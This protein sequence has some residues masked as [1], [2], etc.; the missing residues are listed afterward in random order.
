[1]LLNILNN[2]DGGS[3]MPSKGFMMV[4]I[5]GL[6]TIIIFTIFIFSQKSVSTLPEVEPD[7][8]EINLK[9]I[10]LHSD[11]VVLINNGVN[12]AQLNV[13]G[14][15]ENGIEADITEAKVVFASKNE[16]V[17]TVDNNTGV[18]IPVDLGVVELEA[19]VTLNDKILKSS[20]QLGVSKRELTVEDFEL[21]GQYGSEDSYVERVGANHFKFYR[22]TNRFDSTRK[23]LPQFVIPS[24]FKGNHLIVD[25]QGLAP[26]SGGHNQ[27]MS[28][29]YDNDQWTPVLQEDLSTNGN[30]V[31]RITI[32]PSSNDRLYFGW[33]IPMSY[34][35]G[36]ELIKGWSSHPDTSKY[37][38]LEKLGESYQG[39]EIVKM[40]ITDP[41][42]TVPESERWVHYV[43]H[44]HPHEGKARWR[45]KGLVDWLVSDDPKAKDSRERSIWHVVLNLNPDGANNGFLRH[46][47]GEYPNLMTNDVNRNYQAFQGANEER[48]IKEIYLFQRDMEKLMESNT[49]VHSYWDFHVWGNQVEPILRRG[50]ELIKEFPQYIG[51]Y[52][53]LRDIIMDNDPN[54]L[55][56]PL[57]AQRNGLIGDSTLDGGVNYQFRITSVLVEGGGTLD[58]QEE[59]ESSGEILAKS[60]SQFYRDTP[61]TI[62]AWSQP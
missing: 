22:G 9:S 54:G 8:P 56:K 15:Y 26:P 5:G 40:I 43:S 30:A 61:S 32:A 2:K 46:A 35:R 23:N 31:S 19:T 21:D 33:S 13:T 39:R 6:L 38:K 1:M 52:M 10:K 44:E 24:N 57:K 28:Y 34:E 7:K 29:S 27:H 16:K 3:A 62:E 49:P 45:V 36:M 55:I 25:I 59:N 37:V 42:S 4:A 14:M 60:I 18:V 17:A 41:E 20:V 50:K 51:D 47:Y 12:K 48:Q 11:H 58:S 53:I